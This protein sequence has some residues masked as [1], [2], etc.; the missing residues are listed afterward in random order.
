MCSS[1]LF[2]KQNKYKNLTG[3]DIQD[4]VMHSFKTAMKRD[5]QGGVKGVDQSRVGFTLT[6]PFK[7]WFGKSKIVDESGKPRV[8]YHGTV[9]DIDAFD[10][11]VIFVTKDPSFAN[12]FTEHAERRI[13][14]Q[15][16]KKIDNNPEEKLNLIT[17]AVDQAIADGK[18]AT[19]ENSNGLSNAT[20]EDHI[21]FFMKQ[22]FINSSDSIGLQ[23]YLTQDLRDRMPSGRNILPLYVK[24][25]NPFDYENKTHVNKILNILRK[26]GADAVELN[27]FR[28]AA[29]DGDWYVLEKY[30]DFIKESGF[31]SSYVKE[32][33]E[34]NLAVFNPEQVK[35]ATGNRGTYDINRQIGRAHV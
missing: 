15:I 34:K 16:A 7:R 29:I 11:N 31:D 22:K 23:N 27:Q 4:L 6:E 25:E 3:E 19:K 17:K 21:N 10:T 8:M 32:G 5:L 24:A 18:L 28:K 1:D 13:M 2:L 35:S 9:H 20:R 33:S 26:E 14:R 30:F 12:N